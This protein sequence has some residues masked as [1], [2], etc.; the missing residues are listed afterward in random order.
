MTKLDVLAP[1]DELK[2][3]VAYEGD[4]GTRYDHVPYHQSVLH[5]VRPVYETL[6]GWGTEIDRAERLEDLPREARDYVRFVEELVG[7]PVTFVS[8]GSRPRADRRPAPRRLNEGPRRRRRRAGARAR[9]RA[10]RAARRSTRSSA[11]PATPGWP[12]LGPLRARR[13]RRCRAR[14]PR[15]PTRS[16]PTSRWWARRCRSSPGAVDAVEARGSRRVRA[17]AAAAWLEG[18]K[19]WMKDVLRRRRRAHGAVRVV[20]RRPTKR[21]AL[22]FLET[23]P[24]LYVV[25]TDGLAAGKG[26]V[27]TESHRRGARRGA[28]LP[29]RR[30][31]RR[32]RAHG[33]DRGGTD[34]PRAVAARARLRRR[35]AAARAGPGLQAHRRRRRGPEHRRHGCV[36]AGADRRRRAR[37]R[38]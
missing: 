27:V 8:V 6:P 20:H 7:V 9:R 33:R 13:R 26:V 30:R 5:K 23:L 17:R 14:S 31:V 34:R 16:T 3:C 25:K 36:L 37:R 35:R 11:R 2:V 32:R 38:A 28:R 22:A 10:G 24:G 1:L 29:L 12:T 18:S 4:D 15:S 19:A 21:A